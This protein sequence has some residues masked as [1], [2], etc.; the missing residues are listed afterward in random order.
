MQEWHYRCSLCGFATINHG[1]VE[2]GV[3]AM[4]KHSIQEHRTTWSNATVRSY[5]RTGRG[6]E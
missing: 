4:R 2:S 3:L 5:E 6:A 1:N